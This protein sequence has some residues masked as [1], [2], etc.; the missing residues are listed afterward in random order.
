M[1]LRYVLMVV[2]LAALTDGL[3]AQPGPP[4]PG[5]AKEGER[6]FSE[7]GQPFRER[8][9]AIRRGD[10]PGKG[11]KG[12]RPFL[13]MG[14]PRFEKISRLLFLPEEQL[15]E[16]LDT[17][18]EE[19]EME[20]EEILRTRRLVRNVRSRMEK[21]ADDYA[22]EKGLAIDEGNR[23]EFMKEFV[24][25]QIEA[26]QAIRKKA[27]V[28]LKERREGIDRHLLEKYGAR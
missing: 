18:A 28:E 27:E 7:R 1:V 23:Q 9:K 26:E 19:N 2:G 15:S 11:A 16:A 13:M 20:E 21:K 22:R 3:C 8:M 24:Q 17:W 12:P 10:L 4:R 6:N 25:L 14:D 5:N